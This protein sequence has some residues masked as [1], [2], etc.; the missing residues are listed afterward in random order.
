MQ[1]CLHFPGIVQTRSVRRIKPSTGLPGSM[2]K[3]IKEK[4]ESKYGKGNGDYELGEK[5]NIYELVPNRVPVK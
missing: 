3:S 4:V 2:Y 5:D 1:A